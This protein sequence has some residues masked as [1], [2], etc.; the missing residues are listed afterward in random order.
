MGTTRSTH[1]PLLYHRD[2]YACTVVVTATVPPPPTNVP[3]GSPHVSAATLK[4]RP[5]IFSYFCTCAGA[6]KAKRDTNRPSVLLLLTPASCGGAPRATEV[7]NICAYPCH[8]ATPTQIEEERQDKNPRPGRRRAE[9]R[10]IMAF[11]ASV[12]S[13]RSRCRDR[14]R[15]AG[16]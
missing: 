2:P 4:K 10:S 7:A 16:M 5:S 14:Q 15:G 12:L 3:L 13:T 1:V 11:S 9:R 6:G 8:A